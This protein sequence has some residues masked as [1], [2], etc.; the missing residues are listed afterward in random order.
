M[1]NAGSYLKKEWEELKEKYG[2]M[3]LACEKIEP[4]IKLSVDHIIPLVKGGTNLIA[5]IQPL[6]R[7]CNAKKHTTIVNYIHG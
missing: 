5:N 3:C 4:E 1:E 7:R 6:C 2:F